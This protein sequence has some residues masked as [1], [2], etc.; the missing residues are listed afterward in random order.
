M[1]NIPQHNHAN[2]AEHEQH[3]T[4][5]RLNTLVW[6]DLLILTVITVRIAFFDLQNLTVVVALLVAS[7]KTYLVGA[8]FMHLKFES[9]M[10]NIFIGLVALVFVLVMVILFS[11]YLF[12]Q[13]I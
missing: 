7:V 10:L 6:I 9:K 11:D 2:A 12:R 4:G 8:F 3:G 1:E 5:Y 13:E